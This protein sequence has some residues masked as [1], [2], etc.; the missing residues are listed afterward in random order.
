MIEIKRKPQPAQTAQESPQ[1]PTAAPGGNTT[2]EAQ[3]A[4][5]RP[6]KPF[7]ALDGSNYRAAYRAVCEFHERHNP[8]RLDDDGGESYW[9]TV[10]EDMGEI[11]E[12][13]NQDPFIIE[14]LIA[15]FGELERQF[16]LFALSDQETNIGDFEQNMN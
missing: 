3:N 15:V 1:Q 2:P 6:L 14:M 9:N 16:K 13:F 10:T 11:A 7:T 4:Q 5:K 12:R 8:P